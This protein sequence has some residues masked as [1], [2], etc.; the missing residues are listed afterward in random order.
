MPT[1][2]VT[3]YKTLG[4]QRHHLKTLEDCFKYQY[5]VLFMKLKVNGKLLF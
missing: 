3:T 4:Q 1:N 5:K 2:W